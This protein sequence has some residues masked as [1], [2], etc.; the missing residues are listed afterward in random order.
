[1]S[2]ER[3]VAETNSGKSIGKLAKLN[4]VRMLKTDRFLRR[5]SMV[6]NDAH[7]RRGERIIG[8]APSE[9]EEGG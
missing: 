2:R 7:T 1:M 9:W 5:S 6:A 4:W 3:M 8:K